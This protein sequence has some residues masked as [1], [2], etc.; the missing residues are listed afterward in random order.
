M[1]RCNWHDLRHFYAS[2]LIFKTDLNEAVITELMGHRNISFTAEFYGRW[3][4]DS[5]MEKEIA[6]KLG[7]AFGTGETL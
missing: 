4:Q 7:N 3:F 5:R 1:E 6:E 2:V